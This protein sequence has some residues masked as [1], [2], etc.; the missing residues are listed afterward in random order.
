MAEITYIPRG[1]G[2]EVRLTMQGG[3]ELVATVNGRHDPSPLVDGSEE[4]ARNLALITRLAEYAANELECR[5]LRSPE[6]RQSH[7]KAAD[8]DEQDA[9]AIAEMVVRQASRFVSGWCSGC[10][11]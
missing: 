6:K 7:R 2:C 5:R 10:F 9:V 4:L 1:S 8:R 11:E 3:L